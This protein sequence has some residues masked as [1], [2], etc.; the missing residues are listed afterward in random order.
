M[1][2]T[3]I[4]M[5][6]ITKNW[7]Q[8]PKYRSRYRVDDLIPKFRN[9]KDLKILFIG[10]SPHRDEVVSLVAAERTPFRGFAGRKWWV[11]LGQFLDPP[12]LLSPIP[13][14]SVLLKVCSQL[15]I[16]VLNAVQFPLDPKIILHEGPVCDPWVQ[17]GF[18]KGNSLRGYKTMLETQKN[19]VAK[20]IQDLATRLQP[21]QNQSVQIVAL[22][23]DSKWFVE[24]A[25]LL[26][27][28]KSHLRHQTLCALP[29]P[30]SW[31]RNKKFSHRVQY[32]LE[33]HLRDCVTAAE[34]RKAI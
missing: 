29:H 22:G 17:L 28:P 30:S 16:G 20:A 14:R 8:N 4:F 27:S 31:W 24:R 3:V 23:N 13:S 25:V 21:F 26:L 7:P 32:F 12:Q 15:G 9:K 6:R 34:C 33:T 10:E 1:F 5:P 2:K 11:M 18:E 19:P